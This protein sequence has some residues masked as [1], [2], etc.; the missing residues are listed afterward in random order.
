MSDSI[1][2]LDLRV[3]AE[4]RERLLAAI[5]AVL[6][7]GRLVCGPEVARFESAIADRTGRAHAIGAGSGTDALH[8][9]LR[10][11]DLGPGDEVITTPMS[12]V[13]TA[14]AIALTGATPVFADVDATL[15]IDPR[16]IEA[17]V[18]PR[19]RAIVAVHYNGRV[20]PLDTLDSVARGHDLLLVEDAAQAFGARDASGRESGSTGTIAAFS[21]N[22]MKLL[23]AVGEAGVVVTDDAALRD[24]VERLRYNGSRNEDASE[25]GWNGRLD[26]VQ[27]AVLLARLETIDAQIDHR[28]RLARRYNSALAEIPEVTT[29]PIEPEGERHVYY[30]Y[31][32]E[33]EARDR[34]QEALT[35]AG[36]ETK[37]RHPLL[38]PEQSAYR[39]SARGSWSNAARLRDRM[40]SLP[41]HEK[42]GD[43]EVDRVVETVA[44]F[45][46]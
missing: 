20:A 38:I 3:P 9:A 40:L 44:R 43:A 42:L 36:I 25:I 5:D 7:H 1:P 31:T 26:T 46:R 22:P 10:A 24:R 11:L 27:A 17:E 29:R 4:E 14:N 41:I 30:T 6:A 18:T 32:I 45:F 19:T 8:L 13:A 12:W 28:R 23:A 21:L 35:A 39:E 16:A 2:F 33:V 34:L 15:N 37:V